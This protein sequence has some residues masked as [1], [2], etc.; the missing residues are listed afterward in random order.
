MSKHYFKE[1]DRVTVNWV[2]GPLIHGEVLVAHIHEPIVSYRILPDG[3]DANII[4]PG[5]WV[6]P[7]D[8]ERD[9]ELVTIDSSKPKIKMVVNHGEK[10]IAKKQRGRPKKS[11]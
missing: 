11:K 6:H 1:G 10:T 4:V 8:W 9:M 7:I 5:Q 3:S 2:A